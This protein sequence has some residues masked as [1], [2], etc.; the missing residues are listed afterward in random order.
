MKSQRDIAVLVPAAGKGER[1]GGSEPKQFRLI[2]GKPMLLRSL[3]QFIEHPLVA[4]IVVALPAEYQ[5]SPPDWLASEIGSKLKI[6][7]GGAS[8]ADSVKAAL[9]AVDPSCEV[10][11]VH[12]AARPFVD[13]NT[14]DNVIEAARHGGAVAAVPVSDTIKRVSPEGTTIVETVDRSDLWRAQTPQGCPRKMLE[15]SYTL[16]AE[17]IGW[18][19]TDEASLLENAGFE[20]SIV[21]DV[22]SNFKVTTEADFSI[23]EAL[24]FS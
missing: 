4:Q 1:V 13:R 11:L 9:Y 17:R 15:T 5:S 22:A 10:V 2:A 7:A 24:A 16:A 6:V 20:V 12:D 19:H 14:I 18:E 3:S 8:R 23:A 21:P